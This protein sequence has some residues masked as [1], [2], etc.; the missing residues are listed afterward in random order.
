MLMQ[1][2]KGKD[3][4]SRT[5]FQRKKQMDK[6]MPKPQALCK[7]ANNSD[8]NAIKLMKINIY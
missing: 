6:A 4:D 2:L 3:L 1:A 7:I 5:C 8:S